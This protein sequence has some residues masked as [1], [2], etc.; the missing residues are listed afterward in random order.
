MTISIAEYENLSLMFSNQTLQEFKSSGG[1][2]EDLDNYKDDFIQWAEKR[3]IKQQEQQDLLDNL[4]DKIRLFTN[5][6][7]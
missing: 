4:F 2:Y 5:R 7:Y 1:T 6:P 3:T